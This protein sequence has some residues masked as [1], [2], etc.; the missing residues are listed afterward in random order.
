MESQGHLGDAIEHILTTQA[1]AVWV[2]YFDEAIGSPGPAG[3]G[4]ARFSD[5]LEAAWLYPT[6]PQA[7]LPPI[8]DCYSLNV[9]GEVAY[10]YAYSDFHLVE[11]HG[12]RVNDLG[13][14]PYAGASALLIDGDGGALI[15]GY[16]P[17]Y[18]VVTPLCIRAQSI[19][20][21]GESKRIVM[22][23]GLEVGTPRRL[24]CRGPDLH[25]FVRSGWYRLGLDDLLGE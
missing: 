14:V 5:R 19:E 23:D 16:G 8:D 1:G 7:T 15:S 11:A 4:L 24:F 25:V 9:V 2:G 3:H 21:A 17:D 6:G 13:P 18:D 22:P 20:V 10:C 12:N